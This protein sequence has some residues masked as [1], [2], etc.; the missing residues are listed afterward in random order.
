MNE[1]TRDPFR[2][3]PR[4]PHY[5]LLHNGSGSDSLEAQMNELVEQGYEVLTVIATS[6]FLYAMMVRR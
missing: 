2:D 1:D 3:L 5:R 6:H 4:A